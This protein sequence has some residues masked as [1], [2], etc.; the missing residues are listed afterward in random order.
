MT[1]S[2]SQDRYPFPSVTSAPNS[3]SPTHSPTRQLSPERRGD[4]S[5]H[6]HHHNHHGTP[7]LKPSPPP[8]LLMPP[9]PPSLLIRVARTLYLTARHPGTAVTARTALF[10][11]KMWNFAGA[12]APFA[13]APSSIFVFLAVI[14][15]AAADLG[16]PA[17]L[18]PSTWSLRVSLALLALHYAVLAAASRAGWLCASPAVPRP[19][20]SWQREW[21]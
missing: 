9:P 14:L 19:V 11:L 2:R 5:P 7:T 18:P 17:V 21:R 13:V 16:V 3:R 20:D 4:V 1:I 15:P 6:R 12:C 8:A 10:V